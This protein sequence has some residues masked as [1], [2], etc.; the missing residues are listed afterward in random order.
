[1]LKAVGQVLFS[2]G[3]QN[4]KFTAAEK[5]G[6]DYETRTYHATKWVSTS[7]TGMDWDAAMGTGFRRLFKYIGG[8]NQNKVKVEMTAPVSCFVEPGEGPT[9]ESKFTVSFYIPEEH[10]ATPPEPTDP[11]VFIEHR[12]EFTAYVRTHGGFSNEQM[13]RDEL[14]KLVESLKRDGVEFVDQPFYVAGYDSPFKLTNRRNEVWI[15]QKKP[16]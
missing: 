7:L 1:M 15:L 6:Q 5:Q 2:S 16:E 8:T 13:K 4:P 9:C 14:L 3:L 10:Q 11:D 12:K